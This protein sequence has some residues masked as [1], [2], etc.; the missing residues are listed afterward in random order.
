[1]FLSVRSVLQTQASRVMQENK[2]GLTRGLNQHA[3]HTPDQGQN[4][5]QGGKRKYPGQCPGTHPDLQEM[6][7]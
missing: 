5:Q 3:G 2:S 7:H 1:M 6:I 4:Q